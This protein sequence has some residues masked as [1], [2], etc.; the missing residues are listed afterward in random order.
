MIKYL[1]YL[2]EIQLEE[3]RIHWEGFEPESWVPR[4]A[5]GKRCYDRYE[6]LIA[7]ILLLDPDYYR[8]DD[9]E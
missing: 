9:D 5:Y 6:R 2:A 4:N 7:L 8:R 3:F 1:E